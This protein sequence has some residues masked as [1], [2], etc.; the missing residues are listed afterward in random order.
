MNLFLVIHGTYQDVHLGIFSNEA[1]QDSVVITN[2]QASK[3]LIPSMSTLLVTHQITLKD[4]AFIAVNQGPGPFTTLRTILTTVNSI[5]FASGIPLIGIDTLTGLSQEWP[6]P[7]FNQTITLLDAFNN[8]VYFCMQDTVTHEYHVGY[9]PIDTFLMR[10]A[11]SKHHLRFIGNGA[12][13]H[14]QKIMALCGSNAYFPP[15]MPQACSLSF[16][17][18]QALI[19]WQHKNTTTQ[20][21]P[22]YLKQHQAERQQ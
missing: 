16:I 13:L 10:V 11:Q 8:D 5:C 21:L 2:A 15:D 19:A 7:S 6:D 18:H 3:R 1:L 9:Q 22:L 17:A 14:E 20:L 4:L 12:H